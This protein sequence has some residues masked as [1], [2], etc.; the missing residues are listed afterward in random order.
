MTNI[1]ISFKKV[2]PLKYRQSQQGIV[3]FIAMIALV[4]MSLAGVALIRSVDTNSL[5]AGNLSF[6]QTAVESSSYGVESLSDYLGSKATTYGNISDPA[7]GYYAVCTTTQSVGN[8][9][10]MLLTQAA[11]WQVGAKSRLAD[12]LQ[13]TDGVDAYGNTIEYII[14]RMCTT[15]NAVKTDSCLLARRGTDN[16]SKVVLNE[17]QVGAPEFLTDLPVYR[18]TV[19]VTGPK[20]TTSFVQAFIS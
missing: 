12:G 6:K 15:T 3:L 8:C 2:T 17:P 18:V 4:V 14:E 11:T 16:G 19:R 1:Q 10:G 13:I 7:N 5:I 9:D 20:N